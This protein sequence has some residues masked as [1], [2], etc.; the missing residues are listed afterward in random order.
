MVQVYKYPNL[1][2]RD[3]DT[4]SNGTYLGTAN[5][6]HELVRVLNIER[7][8]QPV[9]YFD[10]DKALNMDEALELLGAY[11]DELDGFWYYRGSIVC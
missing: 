10:G 3:K 7:S 4:K 5:D 1:A 8:K 6:P 11:W 9:N 2:E